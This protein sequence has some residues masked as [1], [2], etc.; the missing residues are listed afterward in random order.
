ML[1]ALRDPTFRTSTF[2]AESIEHSI[3]ALRAMV[4]TLEAKSGDL[5]ARKSQTS[6]SSIT[7]PA[8]G[9]LARVSAHSVRHDL[10]YDMLATVCPGVVKNESVRSI[11]DFVIFS[12][13]RDFSHFQSC[14][15]VCSRN[16]IDLKL[17]GI[18]VQVSSFDLRPSRRSCGLWMINELLVTSD[19]KCVLKTVCSP[20]LFDA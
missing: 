13:F 3:S 10:V 15:R 5:G 16:P 9:Q 14:T 18:G 7:F 6:I 12:Q 4:Q 19:G 11:S 20:S 8:L 1:V 17:S 2:Y